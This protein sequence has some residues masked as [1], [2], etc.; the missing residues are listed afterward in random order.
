MSAAAAA[1]TLRGS[2]LSC[3][4]HCLKPTPLFS[5]FY[6]PPRQLFRR[7]TSAAVLTPSSPC[8]LPRPSPPSS[9]SPVRVRYA[10]SPTGSLHLGGLR[11]ALYNFLLAKQQQR[12]QQQPDGHSK[13]SFI[14]R[15]EDTDQKRLVPGAVVQLIKVLH[16]AGLHFD[17]GQLQSGQLTM[18]PLT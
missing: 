7:I 4:R 1:A 3:G 9:C 14:L 6:D 8:P 12:Q 2:C 13:P 17:E 5:S 11:T 18:A 16:W 10:P 15:I